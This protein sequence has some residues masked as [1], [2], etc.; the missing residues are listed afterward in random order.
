MKKLFF[1]PV[2]ISLG[3]IVAAIYYGEIS[4]FI[5]GDLLT[6]ILT[7][8][9]PFF[10]LLTHFK[11]E[12]I[13]LAF[14]VAFVKDEIEQRI[15]K[16]SIL[17]FDTAFKLVISCSL[18]SILYGVIAMLASLGNPDQ[19]GRGMSAALLSI[20]YAAIYLAFLIIPFRSALQKKLINNQS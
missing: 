3:L 10:L 2:F 15:I 5:Y 16:Q 7:F 19:I 6:F 17:F 11:L 9:I 1:I 14:K 18:V 20:L 13:S 12:E 4:I 8:I